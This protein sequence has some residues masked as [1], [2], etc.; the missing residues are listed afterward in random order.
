MLERRSLFITAQIMNKIEL[1]HPNQGLV[2]YLH[3]I[4]FSNPDSILVIQL[5]RETRM[6]SNSYIEGVMKSIRE[7]L[8][9]V[10]KKIIIIGADINIYELAG[11][12][13]LALKLKGFL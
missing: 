3:Q 9:E 11:E 7:L 5:P 2:G 13:A 12:D 1:H 8:P 4:D 6:I 10:Q